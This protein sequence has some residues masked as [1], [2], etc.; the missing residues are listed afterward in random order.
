MGRHCQDEVHMESSI[1]DPEN[2]T[3]CLWRIQENTERYR[4]WWFHHSKRM[5]SK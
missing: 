3:S 4:I 5:A 1:G 2:G